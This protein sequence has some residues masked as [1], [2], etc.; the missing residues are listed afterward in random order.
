MRSRLITPALALVAGV[1][2]AL[3]GSPATA[4][5]SRATLPTHVNSC[6]STDTLPPVIDSFEATPATV[7]T[8][9]GPATVQLTVTAHDVA[10]VGAPSGVG[11][12]RVYLDAGTPATGPLLGS[13]L[14]SRLTR[15]SD[16]LWHGNVTLPTGT[17]ASY[18]TSVVAW[19][20]SSQGTRSVQGTAGTSRRF[21]GFEV[22]TTTGPATDTVVPSLAG[23]TLEQHARRLPHPRAQRHGHGDRH[24]R[25]LGCAGGD[26]GS[27]PAQRLAPRPLDH[28]RA[29]RSHRP[30][31]REAVVPAMDRQAPGAAERGRRGQLGNAHRLLYRKLAARGL[32]S[33][34]SVVSGPVDMKG[35]R[36]VAV[37]KA[38]RKV[39]VHQHGRWYAVRVVMA[40]PQGARS[41]DAVLSVV[42]Q[43]AHLHRV[44]C[45][46][47]CSCRADPDPSL[48]GVTGEHPP[49][50]GHCRRARHH[51]RRV[52]ARGADPVGRPRGSLHQ[53][54]LWRI[55]EP[56]FRF[57]EP[58]HGI[59]RPTSRSTTATSSRANPLTG[60]WSCRSATGK[61]V[62]CRQGSV[63]EATF[64]P[65]EPGVIPG[66]VVWQAGPAARRPG[67]PRQ[68]FHG[69][70]PVARRQRLTSAPKTGRPLI[71][72]DTT[73]API[74]SGGAVNGSRSRTT[75]SAPFPGT[76]TPA[77]S[78]VA[79]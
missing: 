65:D 76:S 17:N 70:L 36:V 66:I 45:P 19:D 20:K 1:G 5:P 55:H 18:D 4:A 26:R 47:A 9:T 43:G 59:R 39:D 54:I 62:S 31:P 63:L 23:L 57:T 25:R 44:S 51:G 42:S 60:S 40:D 14:Q 34:I 48:S 71:Q 24:R 79:G 30:V 33:Q 16:G 8:T 49:A 35:P 12:V 56:V 2:L 41:V 64:T 3:P 21:P 7:D 32:P 28:P 22:T 29:R 46:A 75:R 53:A 73:V 38:A 37:R 58:V 77:S 67:R 50:R 13:S 68:P 61:K 27:Q 72:V 74:S 52:R 69:Q 10:A 6:W 78:S 11:R 15:G